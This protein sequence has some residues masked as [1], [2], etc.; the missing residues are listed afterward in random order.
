MFYSKGIAIFDC[1]SGK[2]LGRITLPSR[3]HPLNAGFESNWLYNLM[4]V[5]RKR[6]LVM[7]PTV[8]TDKKII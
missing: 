2:C 1:V 6:R 5:D 4:V 8:S 7:A 3:M